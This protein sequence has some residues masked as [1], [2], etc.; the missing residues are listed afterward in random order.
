M[1]KDLYF[2]LE[3]REKLLTLLLATIAAVVEAAACCSWHG[4]KF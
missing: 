2:G 3:N 1:A 4:S